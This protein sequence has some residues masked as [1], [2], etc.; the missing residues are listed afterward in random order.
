MSGALAAP[1][2]R[3]ADGSSDRDPAE[4]VLPAAPETVEA[5][6]GFVPVEAGCAPAPSA[7]VASVAGRDAPGRC[8]A[9]FFDA[10]V[11]P[12]VLGGEALV[13][14]LTAATLVTAWLCGPAALSVLAV[15]FDA[16]FADAP[17]AVDVGGF[18]LTAVAGSFADSAAVLTADVVT[19]AWAPADS[20]GALTVAEALVGAVLPAV[21]GVATVP[22][23]ACT[24]PAT[25]SSVL[26]VAVPTASMAFCTAELMPA[27]AF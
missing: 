13:V 17:A 11:L 16:A 15:V 6:V 8:A 19:G 7:L 25:V 24:A 10:G 18:V 9:V 5:V 22:A 3:V 12:P 21:F 14:A 4:A 20:A 23:S 2:R 27:A 1:T 26:C